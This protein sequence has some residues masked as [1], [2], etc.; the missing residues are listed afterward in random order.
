MVDFL[1]DLYTCFDDIIGHF[2]VYKVS[3]QYSSFAL[4]NQ[5][6]GKDRKMSLKWDILK[7]KSRVTLKLFEGA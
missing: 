4:K 6:K 5:K 7:K 2:D 1:N 3:Y